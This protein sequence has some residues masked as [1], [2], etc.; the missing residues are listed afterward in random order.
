[1]MGES[2]K[3]DFSEKARPNFHNHLRSV[4]KNLLIVFYIAL[5]KKAS[6]SHVRT[7]TDTNEWMAHGKKR[8]MVKG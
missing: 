6:L 7:H 8:S 1:M 2:I 3:R 5:E 4:S